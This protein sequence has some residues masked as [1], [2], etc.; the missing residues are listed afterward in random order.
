VY[1]LLVLVRLNKLCRS[2]K[3]A[4][5]ANPAIA[6]FWLSYIDTL[7]KLDKLA[8]AKAVLDQAKSKGA[9]G[10]GFDKL[11]Q[12]LQEAGKEPLE[13]SKVACRSTA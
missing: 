9:K 13:A 7:I 12:Q 1:W 6:Q 5:E 3:T 4:L 10:D 2:F 11:E 8:D